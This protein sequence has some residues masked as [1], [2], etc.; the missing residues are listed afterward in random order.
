MEKP[1]S[2]REFLEAYDRGEFN[3]PDRQTQVKAGWYDWFCKDTSLVAKTHKLTKKLKSILPSSKINIDKNYV[4]FKNN[5]PMVGNLYDD[6]RIADIETGQSIYCIIPSSGFKHIKGQISVYDMT[7]KSERGG[8]ELIFD[9]WK[10]LR[11][12]FQS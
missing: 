7:D 10:D 2:I 3:S 12:Y 4:W 11:K 1:L 9:S 6:L 8:K 5:C